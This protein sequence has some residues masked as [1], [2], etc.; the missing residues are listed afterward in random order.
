[1]E[2]KGERMNVLKKILEEIDTEVQKQRELYKDLRGTPGYRLYEKTAAVFKGIVEKH[3]DKVDDD[4][5]IPVSERLPN[6]HDSIFAKI[7]GTDKW[8]EAMFE[9]T[10][11][12]VNVTIEYEDGNR[13]TTTS[14][15]LDGVWKIE[16]EQ[17]VVKRKVIAWQSLPEPYKGG[18]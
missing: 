17:R 16:K 11:D 12:E 8:C 3:M 14:Y 5:W 13:K 9:K 6:E 10:S 1:M 4:G 2:Q 7:K 15:T 18:E